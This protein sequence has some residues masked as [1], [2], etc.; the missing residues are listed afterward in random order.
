MTVTRGTVIQVAEVQIERD[1]TGIG[2]GA[3]GVAGG[4][5]GSTI[6][7][8]RGTRLASVGGALGGAAA[9]SAIENVRN[10]K[11]ALEIEVDLDDGRYLVNVQEADDMFSPGEQVRVVEGSDGRVRVRKIN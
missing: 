7:G 4:V 9:G 3:V 8:G 1:E 10:T 11:A 5:V 6:G 2:A